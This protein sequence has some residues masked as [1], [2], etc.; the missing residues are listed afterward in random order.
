[1]IG[2]LL[3]AAGAGTRMGMPKALV[4]DDTG[5]AWLERSVRV[6]ELGGCD[7]I[8]VVLGASSVE[9]AR[10]VPTGTR[11][12]VAHDWAT[13]MSV[14]LRAGLEAL[15][16]ASSVTAVLVHL[17]D[18][19]DVGAGVVRRLA[20]RATGTTALARAC[21]EGRPGHPVLIGRDHWQG[22]VSEIEG[23]RGARRYLADHETTLIECGDLATGRDRD[24]RSQRG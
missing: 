12:V 21:Y 11:V 22:V 4:R 16:E 7:E 6:L 2:G 18:L 5:Q 8:T 20:A 13:G 24:R 3:L 23:D 14:S 9:A 15:Q 17:V 19:P 1:M 10:L